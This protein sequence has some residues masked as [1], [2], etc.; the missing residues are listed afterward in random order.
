MRRSGAEIALSLGVL[1]LG[2]G[3][4][5]VTATLP[6]ESGYAGIGPNFTPGVVS[7]GLIALGAWLAFE[8]FSGGW[9]SAPPDNA[10]ERGE[11]PFHGAAFGWI[12]AGLFAQMALIGTAG[13]VVAATVLFACVARG[14]G[15]RRVARDL[16]IG[17]VLALAIFLFFV[18]ALNVNLPAG[19]LS[20]ILGGAGI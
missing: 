11:H 9:R 7:A 4:A 6:S 20:P 13:F 14:F 15:S 12:T 8:A 17:A 18:Q 2:V 3:A 10:R 5:A 16:A 1:A 19:W